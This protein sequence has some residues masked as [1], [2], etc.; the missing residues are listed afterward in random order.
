MEGLLEEVTCELRPEGRGGGGS[1]TWSYRVQGG[2]AEEEEGGSPLG[3]APSSSARGWASHPL[4]LAP[5]SLLPQGKLWAFASVPI[6]PVNTKIT[7]S[8][9]IS[10]VRRIAPSQC[11]VQCVRVCA[12]VCMCVSPPPARSPIHPS[13]SVSL[14]TS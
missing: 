13:E 2:Q 3:F 6:V 9:W 14:P 1:K 7:S 10:T 11:P 8:R 4:T 12:C 5:I